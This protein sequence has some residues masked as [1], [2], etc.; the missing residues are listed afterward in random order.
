MKEESEDPQDGPGM[1]IGQRELRT[2][3]ACGAK[4]SVTCDS[5]FCPVC[6]LHEALEHD[7]ETGG[8]RDPELAER[9]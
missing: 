7:Q 9:S 5:G 1:D 2:C 6:V 3:A 8:Q 4:F